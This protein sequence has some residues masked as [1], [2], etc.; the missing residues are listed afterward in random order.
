MGPWLGCL[1]GIRYSDHD[2]PDSLPSE[3]NSIRAPYE[4][5]GFAHVFVPHHHDHLNVHGP[6][7]LA[8]SL[9]RRLPRVV[10]TIRKQVPRFRPRILWLDHRRSSL[11]HPIERRDPHLL[12][13]YSRSGQSVP[14]QPDHEPGPPDVSPRIRYTFLVSYD[15]PERRSGASAIRYVRQDR[16]VD[17]ERDG[18]RLGIGRRETVRQ[19]VVRSR[20]FSDTVRT[21]RED[22][23]F[24]DA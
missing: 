20:G 8:D 12:V 15:K 10:F 21:G 19:E 18:V 9:R 24:A 13:H 23:T 5:F 14:V 22:P 11:D 6:S 3:G 1:H 4:R 7:P 16:H 17:A 2:E